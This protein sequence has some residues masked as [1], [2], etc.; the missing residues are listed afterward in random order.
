MQGTYADENVPS[1]PVNFVIHQV[2]GMDRALIQ[3]KH[4]VLPV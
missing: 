3:Y 1:S 2:D 4:V